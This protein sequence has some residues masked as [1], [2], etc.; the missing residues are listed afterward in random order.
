VTGAV[1]E[2]CEGCASEEGEPSMAVVQ[3]RRVLRRAACRTL[4]GWKRWW[5]GRKNYALIAT[6]RPRGPQNS[7]TELAPEGW[8]RPSEPPQAKWWQRRWKCRETGIVGESGCNT[9]GACSAGVAMRAHDP[10]LD[11]LGPEVSRRAHPSV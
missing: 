5:K 8:P 10:A 9:G 3:R 4:A 2:V 6:S 7:S 1:G 11:P